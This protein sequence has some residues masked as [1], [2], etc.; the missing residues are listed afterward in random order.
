LIGTYVKDTQ[1]QDWYKENLPNAK[2]VISSYPNIAKIFNN[3]NGYENKIYRKQMRNV[4]ILKALPRIGGEIKEGKDPFLAELET[5]LE[6]F[7]IVGK[8]GNDFRGL[9]SRLTSDNYYESLT[10]HT[11]LMIAGKF[12]DKI[13]LTNVNLFPLLSNSKKSDILL[14]TNN[15]IF[16][17]EVTN[18][19]ERMSQKKIQN[20]I[21]RVAEC[22]GKKCKPGNYSFFMYFNKETIC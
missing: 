21:D 22:I 11:E 17:V 16:F 1:L 10:A 2:S 3:C 18:L 20:I 7:D 6:S 12:A 19:T 14:Q 13:G 9:V 4:V 5:V 8:S 15:K